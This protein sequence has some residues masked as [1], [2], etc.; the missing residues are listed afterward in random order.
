[1]IVGGWGGLGMGRTR[2]SLSVT[3]DTEGK[4]G[5]EDSATK[6]LINLV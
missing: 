4:L 3:D 6:G 1:M 2:D 5:D